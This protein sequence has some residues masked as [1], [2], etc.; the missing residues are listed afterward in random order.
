V[1]VVPTPSLADSKFGCYCFLIVSEMPLFV[2]G[3]CLRFE[4]F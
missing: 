4:S 2:S 1:G 3:G